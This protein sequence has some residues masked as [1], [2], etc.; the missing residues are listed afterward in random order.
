M[1]EVESQMQD[2]SPFEGVTPSIAKTR[3]RRKLLYSSAKELRR[4]RMRNAENRSRRFTNLRGTMKS[5]TSDFANLPDQSVRRPLVE[6]EESTPSRSNCETKQQLSVDISIAK[7]IQVR[8]ISNFS[9][10]PFDPKRRQIRK[11]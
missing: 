4:A 2:V 5:L 11:K 10:R 3:K 6:L 1:K 8:I 7:E 9:I